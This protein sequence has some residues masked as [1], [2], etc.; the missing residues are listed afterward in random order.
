[1]HL[2]SVLTKVFLHDTSINALFGHRVYQ[3]LKSATQMRMGQYSGD[4]TE[5]NCYTVDKGQIDSE[6]IRTYVAE[7]NNN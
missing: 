7:I 3:C 4:V 5:T 1:M 6:Q 2:H